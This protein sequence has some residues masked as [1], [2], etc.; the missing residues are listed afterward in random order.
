MSDKIRGVCHTRCYWLETLW[1]PG[2]VYEGSDPLCKHFSADGKLDKPIPPP[3]PGDDPRSTNTIRNILKDK[4]N[5]DY[6]KHWS[7]KK[8]WAAL[9]DFETMGSRDETTNPSTGSIKIEAVT[10]KCGFLAK[11][12]AWLTAHERQCSKCKRG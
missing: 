5:S 8:V 10:A 9:I 1:E 6:P 2:E 3:H 4:Y 11:S 12:K 7:R